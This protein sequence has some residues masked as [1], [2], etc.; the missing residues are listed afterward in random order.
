MDLD[1]GIILRVP[2]AVSVW[3]EDAI[4]FDVAIP[5]GVGLEF[6]VA[7]ATSRCIVGNA[8]LQERQ[9]RYGVETSDSERGTN[10]N[11]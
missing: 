6:E 3:R 5:E 8:D 2:P 4:I 11:L 7:D 1:L 10:S 9:V